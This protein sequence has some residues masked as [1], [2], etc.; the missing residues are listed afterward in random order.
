[1]K[2]LFAHGWGFDRHFWQ[3]LA[4]L[5]GQWPQV[6]DDRGYFGAPASPIVEGPCVA[7]THSFGT[8]R[9]LAAPPAGLAG[10]VAI[11]GFDRF[12]ADEGKPGVPQRVLDRMVLRFETQPEK[13]LS[14]FRRLCGCEE[15]FGTIDAAAL[16]AD[17][18]RLRATDHS[19]TTV[20]IVTLHGE[21]DPL[22]PADM[23]A[24]TLPR[25]DRIELPDGGH[26]L[27]VENPHACAAAVRDMMAALSR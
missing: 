12:V 23:R 25:A 6:I 24:T 17:L 1:M 20:P 16:K 9:V 4:A 22:L 13:V 8:M 5:L 26:L 3:P 11:N 14:D 2:L 15:P 21:R 19:P 10:I 7:V 18:L 27:P